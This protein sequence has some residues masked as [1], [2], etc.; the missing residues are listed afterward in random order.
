MLQLRRERTRV[1]ATASGADL[2]IPVHHVLGV[3][4]GHRRYELLEEVARLI[5]LRVARHAGSSA[6]QVVGGREGRREGRTCWL[7]DRGAQVSRLWGG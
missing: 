4:V 6:A 7:V 2:Q 1:A 5:L 3:T